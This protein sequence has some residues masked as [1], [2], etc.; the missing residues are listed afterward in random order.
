M[1]KYQTGKIL[2][3]NF[4]L[5]HEN[6]FASCSFI[7]GVFLVSRFGNNIE[8]FNVEPGAEWWAT[9]KSAGNAAQRID[10]FGSAEERAPF[11]QGL[12]ST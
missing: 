3:T 7:K 5:T 10:P 9:P 6:F 11:G 1:V 8:K 2:S 12:V 4:L